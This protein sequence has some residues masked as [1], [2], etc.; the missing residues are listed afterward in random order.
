MLI[1]IAI[2]SAIYAREREESISGRHLSS[3]PPVGC[4]SSAHQAQQP[5]LIYEE[6]LQHKMTNPCTVYLS[7]P[8]RAEALVQPDRA[9]P[10]QWHCIK[11]NLSFVFVIYRANGQQ[12]STSCPPPPL[13]FP[14]N[15]MAK[16]CVLHKKEVLLMF[17]KMVATIKGT[18]L[19]IKLLGWLWK[20]A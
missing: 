19:K 5:T 8:I 15:E 20:S 10:P 9:Y 4:E 18:A 2:N 1:L 6:T 11:N 13:F 3:P 17:H 16:G 12:I 14:L 7:P